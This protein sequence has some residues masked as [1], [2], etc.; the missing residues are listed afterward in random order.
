MS[1][2][3]S[4]S[5][6]LLNQLSVGAPT[7]NMPNKVKHQQTLLEE[8]SLFSG[9]L[10]EEARFMENSLIITGQAILLTEL[11]CQFAHCFISKTLPLVTPSFNPLPVTQ[12]LPLSCLT[13]SSSCPTPPSPCYSSA[14]RSD[15][16]DS[17]LSEVLR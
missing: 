5:P 6:S 9:Y 16:S 11:S 10:K 7:V 17:S 14:S 2:S 15:D 4:T 12:R 13:L 1:I 8:Y 3:V